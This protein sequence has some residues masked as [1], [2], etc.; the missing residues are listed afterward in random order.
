MS[1]PARMCASAPA[2]AAGATQ[3]RSS[4]HTRLAESSLP[5]ASLVP[6]PTTSTAP[7]ASATV[8][9]APAGSSPSRTTTT[10]RTGISAGIGHSATAARCPSI[11]AACARRGVTQSPARCTSNGAACNCCHSAS[12]GCLMDRADDPVA[13]PLGLL[14]GRMVQQR[15]HHPA[16]AAAGRRVIGSHADHHQ[17][18]GLADPLGMRA[19]VEGLHVQGDAE[20]LADDHAGGDDLHRAAP[21]GQQL[22]GAGGL[23]EA[24]VIDHH[25]LPGRLGAAF[26]HVADVH[27]ARM[28]GSPVRRL[29][30][31]PGGQHHGVGRIGAQRL[32]RGLHAGPDFHAV[33][34]AFGRQVAHHVEELGA[35]WHRCGHGYLAAGARLAFVQRHPVA[36]LGS[37]G[38]CLQAGRPTA[39]HDHP[40]ARATRRREQ[41]GLPAGAGVLDAAQPPV[42][43]HPADAFLVAGQARCGSGWH[44][45]RGPWRRSRGRRSGRAP[46][47]PGRS[48]PRPAHA[49]P[50]PGP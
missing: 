19:H 3:D 10:A 44:T 20:I 8:S 23:V 34:L 11:T 30:P 48:V 25:Y 42:Q 47:P 28:T 41:D 16:G 31:R 14:S 39:D 37:R 18:G 50:G 2:S 1:T 7:P 36:A 9:S 17:V 38:G 6:D 22:G 33:A 35:G 43:A 49:R 21:V 27:Y 5:A 15:E 29:R 40:P 32:G 4:T 46:R 13:E 26:E 45:P 24:E 12:S